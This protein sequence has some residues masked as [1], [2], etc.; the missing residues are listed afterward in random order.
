MMKEEGAFGE[1]GDDAASSYSSPTDQ[2]QAESPIRP[3]KARSLEIDNRSSERAME[4]VAIGRMNW[5][6]YVG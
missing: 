5:S 1:R 6:G 3:L 2:T 4:L